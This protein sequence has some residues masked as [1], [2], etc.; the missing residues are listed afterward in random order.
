MTNDYPR[1]ILMTCDKSD[2]LIP[3]YAHL[4]RKYWQPTP[5]V[6]VCGFRTPPDLCGFD[7]FSIGDFADY[8]IDKWSDAFLKVLDRIPDEVFIFMLEDYWLYRHVDAQAIKM[9]YDYM[10]QFTNVLKIDICSDRL[11]A[12]GG[13]P[14]V[15]DANTYAHLNRLDLIQSLPGW[16][17]HMSL[18][19]GMFR[20][21]LLK[22]LIIPGETA[23][24][25]E[26][27]G[28]TRLST[29]HGDMLVLGT[30]QV[31]LRHGNILRGGDKSHQYM[32]TGG[33]MW[34]REV[35]LREMRE[36]GLIE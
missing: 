14:F 27:S 11:G 1:I 33:Q 20:R 30:R 6:L 29:K 13:Q 21:D 23:Q 34:M 32:G 17:Y 12:Q 24:Q 18:W 25:I 8:P 31:P 7:F 28:T 22:R 35:D 4:L 26:M 9:L 3:G 5:E 19:A 2:Y 10:H 16:D 36:M 15:Q